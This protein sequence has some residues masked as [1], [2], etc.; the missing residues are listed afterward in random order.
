[1]QVSGDYRPVDLALAHTYIPALYCLFK[2]SVLILLV[3]NTGAVRRAPLL[4]LIS[5]PIFVDRV[6]RPES[7]FDSNSLLCT[8][9]VSYLVECIRLEHADSLFLASSPETHGWW[10][11]HG[12]VWAVQSLAVATCTALI[13]DCPGLANKGVFVQGLVF[14]ALTQVPVAHDDVVNK[15]VMARSWSFVALC[16]VWTYAIGVPEMV[17]LLNGCNRLPLASMVAPKSSARRGTQNL[18]VQSFTPCIIR[19]GPLLLMTGWWQLI[20]AATMAT[21]LALRILAQYG[22]GKDVQQGGETHPEYCIDS[23]FLCIQQEASE[24]DGS[25]SFK[26]T[27]LHAP[28]PPDPKHALQRDRRDSNQEGHKEWEAQ[29]DAPED[30]GMRWQHSQQ[31]AQPPT[32]VYAQK[33]PGGQT[34]MHAGD[35]PPQAT[36]ATPGSQGDD[37]GDMY[38]LFRKAKQAQAVD[39]APV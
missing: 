13:I 4:M 38:Q 30:T 7:I 5:T 23:N 25:M 1:M 2:T 24:P 36:E 16:L 33:Q 39:H 19:F 11:R 29:A 8:L 31:H 32:R 14:A 22:T 26:R 28:E 10:Q 20:G 27:L 34:P 6:T 37:D 9:H 12:V 15:V 3:A 21:C 35:R 17:R 18:V